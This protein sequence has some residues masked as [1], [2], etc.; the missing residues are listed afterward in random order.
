MI[1]NFDKRID[2]YRRG[3]GFTL[4]ELLVV[5]AIIAILL[6]IS[7]PALRKAKVLTRRMVCQSNL[8]QIALAWHVYIDDHD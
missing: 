5:I 8:R 3:D 1:C 2:T 6:A 7:M 4:M